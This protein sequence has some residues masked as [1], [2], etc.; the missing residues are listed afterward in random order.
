MKEETG[1][2]IQIVDG[3]T[4]N[5]PFDIQLAMKRCGHDEELLEEVMQIFLESFPKQWGQLIQAWET[6]DST[7][8]IRLTHTLKNSCDNLGALAAKEVALELERKLPE[9]ETYSP[10]VSLRDQ[11]QSELELLKNSLRTHLKDSASV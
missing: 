7:N 6:G 5:S 9:A 2:A 3:A 8:T 11:L 10:L 4:Q 1:K